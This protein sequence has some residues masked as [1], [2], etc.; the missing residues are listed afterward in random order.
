MQENS[1]GRGA[2]GQRAGR[3]AYHLR[4]R[5]LGAGALRAWG[6]E[7]PSTAPH[8]G[9]GQGSRSKR[10]GG[11][12]HAGRVEAYHVSA[13]SQGRQVLGAGMESDKNDT[14]DISTGEGWKGESPSTAS[15]ALA[16]RPTRTQHPQ[17]HLHPCPT[18]CPARAAPGGPSSG[19]GDEGVTGADLGLSPPTQRAE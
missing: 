14:A 7:T 18:S 2:A 17:G 13:G 5:V 15:P 9:T 6:E 1:A 8:A 10:E 3:A 11:K 16:A 19:R 4:A 12:E